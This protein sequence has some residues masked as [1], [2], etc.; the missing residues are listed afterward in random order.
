MYLHAAK[1]ARAAISVSSRGLLEQQEE[2]PQR[3]KMVDI[4]YVSFYLQRVM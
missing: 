4:V 1:D 3:V 2:D